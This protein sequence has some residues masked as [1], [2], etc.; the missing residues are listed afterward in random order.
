MGVG[1]SSGKLSF[2]PQGGL[3]PGEKVKVGV[4]KQRLQILQKG[5]GGYNE[6][7]DYILDRHLLLEC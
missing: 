1:S 7:M 2:V 4:N 5:H 3:C 6:E